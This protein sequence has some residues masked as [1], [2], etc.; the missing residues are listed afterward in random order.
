[1]DKKFR[2]G[3]DIGI[4]SVGW[5]IVDEKEEIIDAGV[6]LFP[7]GGSIVTSAKRREKR[8]SRR[9]LRRRG[10]RIE[11]L[12]KLLLDYKIIDTLNYDFYIN[13][14]TPYELRVK[15]LNENLTKRE[16]A[17]VLLNLVKK[18]GIHNFEIKAKES[19]EEKGT[20][21]ILLQNEKKL[22]EKF[23][24]ELQL[25]RLKTNDID[26][27]NGAVRGKR[28]VFRTEDYVREAKQI[29]NT[30]KNNNLDI[31]EKFIER[32]IK[33]LEGRR[34]Y[35]TGPGAPSI[36]GWKDEEEWIEGLFGKCTYFPSE[37]RMCKHSYT[38]ELFNLLNDLNNLKIKREE[39]NSLTTVEKKNLIELFKN[40]NPTLK[41][42][43]DNIGIKEENLSGYR[44]DNKK[45]PLFTSLKSYNDINSIF[46]I[47]DT[48]LIDE[49][50]KIL[51]IYQTNDKIVEKIKEL[52][53]EITEEQLIK[54][55]NLNSY[56]GSH[57][58]SKKAMMCILDEL[59]ETSKNQME[60][61]TEK[62]LIPY[63]MDF[64][65]KKVIPKDYV[66]KW[67][68]SPVVKRS[69]SQTI[70]II[71]SIHKKYGIPN[72]V[73]IEMA[74]EKNSDD[75]K[76]FLNE[77]QS[78]NEKMNKMIKEYL[79]GNNFSK[80]N[81][82]FEKIKLWKEQSGICIYSGKVIPIEDLLNRP[83]I[84]EIDHIIPRSI[85]FDDGQNN[86]VL[87]MR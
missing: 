68:L 23:V 24:C 54:I 45:N 73:V 35:Y 18:R 5:A 86:K 3:L 11:R 52:G 78:K 21:D 85:S 81:G 32:F 4:A 49:I 72:E 66:E 25:E 51:T 38:A 56:T 46:G 58:L 17:I 14:V 83:E 19:D 43:A 47:E 59:L 62:G 37:I 12:R 41:R 80:E 61:F 69:V 53:I 64:T 27:D 50:S 6:R 22:E 30:Q 60:L 79:S 55:N 15:G 33:I 76:K 42:I 31:T 67:I 65:G 20:K 87:V 8:A 75:R 39:N 26:S 1:M 7:E 84:F 16:L 71:N 28:N 57:S 13:E 48:D 70:N 74:R 9:L 77:L 44:I 2:L 34:K 82:F 10:H 36:Y 40:Q 29:L 63:K